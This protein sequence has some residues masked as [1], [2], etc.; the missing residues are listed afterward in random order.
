MKNCKNVIVSI[1]FISLALIFTI[2][3]FSVAAAFSEQRKF[4]GQE[5]DKATGL[6]YLNARYYD[7]KRGQF[8]TQDPLARD[9]PEQFLADPQQLNSY[10]YAK[11]N[12]ITLSD[13]SGF[14]PS[15]LQ[16]AQMASQ[17]YQNGHEGDNLSGGWQYNSLLPGS[18]TKTGIYSRV[19][20]DKSTEY[21][22][23]GR[24]TTNWLGSDLIN[25]FGQPFN[26]SPDMSAS[27][28][29]ATGFVNN[30]KSNEVTFVGHSKAG[31]EAMADAIKT[32]NNAIIFNP[33][34]LNASG[35][36]AA[37][38]TAQVDEY[39]VRGE[40]L[41]SIFGPVSTTFGSHDR[42]TYLPA[43]HSLSSL[44]RLLLGPTISSVIGA[45]NS[46]QN[47]SMESVINGLNK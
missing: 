15:P 10:S 17:I 19:K 38:Y 36:N 3:H 1:S 9:N 24:G 12:P 14:I 46:Y 7:A 42:I 23:V 21:A 47:H 43:Q 37:R 33:A 34:S 35:L 18:G 32:N 6:D 28:K 4:I 16:G 30:H 29:K 45:Y 8:I 40:P 41:N 31:A 2:P 39:I 27:I 20:E 11:N 26:A 5:Y 13:P 22:L 25:N 44:G